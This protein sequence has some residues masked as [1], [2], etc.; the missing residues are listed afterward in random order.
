MLRIEI[1]TERPVRPLRPSGIALRRVVVS[2]S[3]TQEKG[4]DYK[5]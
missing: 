1:A 3:E 2:W 5:D 4:L